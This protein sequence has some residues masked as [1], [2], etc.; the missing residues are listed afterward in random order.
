[1]HVPKSF[2]D[3]ELGQMLTW[4]KTSV[5]IR[6]LRWWLRSNAT[7]VSSC[8]I[9]IK[10]YGSP[11]TYRATI[12][13]NCHNLFDAEKFAEDV[14]QKWIIQNGANFESEP[15][16]K[17]RKGHPLTSN[18]LEFESDTVIRLLEELRKQNC[19]ERSVVEE[20]IVETDE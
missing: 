18:T 8:R 10:Q 14:V 1:M 13:Q 5:S 17:W 3:M 4:I 19:R 2:S 11:H 16:L 7:F 9:R 20:L 15:E 12:I 6:R